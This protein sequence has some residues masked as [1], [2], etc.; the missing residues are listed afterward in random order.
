VPAKEPA[1]KEEAPAP[2]EGD[3]EAPEEDKPEDNKDAEMGEDKQ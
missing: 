1:K 3:K 2:A